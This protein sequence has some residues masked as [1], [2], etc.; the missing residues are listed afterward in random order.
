MQ[1]RQLRTRWHSSRL[2]RIMPV[3]LAVFPNLPGRASTAIQALQMLLV[4]KRVHARPE[5]V[6]VISDQLLLQNE[7]IKRLVD[8]FLAGLHVVEYP[9]AENE[10]TAVDQHAAIVDGVNSRYEIR[11][12]T[13]ERYHVITQVG[14][15]TEKAG[16]LVIPVK[17]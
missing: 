6:M 15:Y 4:L 3:Y 16:N 14:P 17:V 2:A 5:A 7:A 8:E 12:A 10:I 9:A 1:I 11:A 13:M